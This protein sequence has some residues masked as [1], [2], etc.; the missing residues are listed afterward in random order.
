MCRK[1]LSNLLNISKDE[2]D[3]TDDLFTV[4]ILAVIKSKKKTIKIK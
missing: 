4:W 1:I 2:D 3:F